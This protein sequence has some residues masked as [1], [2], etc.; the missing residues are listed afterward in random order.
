[1]KPTVTQIKEAARRYLKI[2][3]WSDDDQCYIGSAPPLVGQSCHGATEAAVIKQLQTIVEEWVAV[4]ITDGK[5]LPEGTAN[6]RFS[7]KFVVRLSPEAHRKVALKA[8][9]SPDV[10]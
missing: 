2:V 8:M 7:G 5:P 9:A 1:M 3:E 4:L 6:R 10:S